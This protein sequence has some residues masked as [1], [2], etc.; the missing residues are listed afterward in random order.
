[1]A[2]YVKCVRRYIEHTV[3]G[4]GYEIAKGENGKWYIRSKVN[5]AYGEWWWAWKCCGDLQ[6]V[7]RHHVTYENTNGN[8]IT[9]HTLWFH[10]RDFPREPIVITYD[11]R[12]NSKLVPN[13]RLPIVD[14]EE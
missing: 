12:Y 7:S 14:G 2:K 10:F 11:S 6:K 1:M 3:Y 5:L 4:T 8:E 9:D 13:Y